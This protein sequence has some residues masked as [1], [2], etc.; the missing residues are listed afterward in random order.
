[1]SAAG[2]GSS[3]GKSGVA[4][5]PG[6]MLPA[7]GGTEAQGLDA[8]APETFFT[9]TRGGPGTR[10]NS[11]EPVFSSASSPDTSPNSATSRLPN[12]G[13]FAGS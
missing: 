8:L 3:S 13:T 10:P 6:A 4:P 7:I 11:T 2:K 9:L 5:Y 1:M 12:F